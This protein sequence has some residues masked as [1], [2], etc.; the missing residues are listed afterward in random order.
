M[1]SPIAI[2]ALVLSLSIAGASAASSPLEQA[3]LEKRAEA[4]ARHWPGSGHCYLGRH[5]CRKIRRYE[6]RYCRWNGNYAIC[7]LMRWLRN[8][9]CGGWWNRDGNHLAESGNVESEAPVVEDADLDGAN[10]EEEDGQDLMAEDEVEEDTAT[11]AK[12]EEAKG[13]WGHWGCRFPRR[14]CRKI[15]RYERTYCRR[16]YNHGLC[17]LF[18]HLHYNYCYRF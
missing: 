18:R 1:R 16:H 13:Q 9:Y 2:F 3:L 14:K 7:N 6:A 5:W 15:R 17:S 11:V 10:L 8:R 12:R 4:S